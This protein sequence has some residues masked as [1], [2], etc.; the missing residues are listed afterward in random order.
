MALFVLGGGHELVVEE[1]LLLLLRRGRVGRERERVPRRLLRG[2]RSGQCGAPDRGTSGILFRVI[3]FVSLSSAA[4]ARVARRA[5]DDGPRVFARAFVFHSGPTQRHRH[6]AG[7]SHRVRRRSCHFILTRTT[8]FVRSAKKIFANVSARVRVAVRDGDVRWFRSTERRRVRTRLETSLDSGADV[9]KRARVVLR[10]FVFVLVFVFAREGN[11]ARAHDERV[12]EVHERRSANA[13]RFRGDQKRRAR[14]RGD[15]RGIRGRVG[16][17]VRRTRQTRVRHRASRRDD[18]RVCA[19]KRRIRV[20][21]VV[22][23]VV[24]VLLCLARADGFFFDESVVLRE[25]ARRRDA[26][27]A[28]AR[29]KSAR[30]RHPRRFRV[31]RLHR[32]V[33]PAKRDARRVARDARGAHADRRAKRAVLEKIKQS[34][35]ERAFAFFFCRVLGEPRRASRRRRL[36]QRLHHVEPLR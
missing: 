27:R 23:V 16:R 19:E 8:R 18:A 15:R 32:R 5:I 31:R 33:R 14:R 2:R 22:V 24:V 35:R 3:F 1:R 9:Q 20:V 36:L 25:P 30:D 26:A 12:R 13:R 11:G 29:K 17:P 28:V 10:P 6:G 21:V 7:H 34:L 4:R